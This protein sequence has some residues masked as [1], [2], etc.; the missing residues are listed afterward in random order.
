MSFLGICQPK[1]TT[2]QSHCPKTGTERKLIQ[3]RQLYL[4]TTMA[5][6]IKEINDALLSLDLSNHV[7]T[8]KYAP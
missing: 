7:L 5:P 2:N 4:I 1:T 8:A 6:N 3:H